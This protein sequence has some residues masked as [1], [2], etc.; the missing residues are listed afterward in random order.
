ME[1]SIG[2]HSAIERLHKE[3]IAEAA[4]ADECSEEV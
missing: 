3:F 1:S 4:A 2:K